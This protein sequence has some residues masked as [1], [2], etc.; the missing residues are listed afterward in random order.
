[1]SEVL[2]EEVFREASESIEVHSPSLAAVRQRAGEQRRRRRSVVAGSAAACAV[3]VGLAT[4]WATR[5]VAPVDPVLTVAPT[6][7]AENPVDVAWFANGELHLDHV[8]IELPPLQELVAISGGAVYA[9]EGGDVVFVA[10]DGAR[11]RLGSKDPGTPLVGSDER[12]WVAWTDTDGREP[13]LVLYDLTSRHEVRTVSPTGSQEEPLTAV[14]IDQDILYY[15]SGE[16]SYAATPNGTSQQLAPGLL[17]VS[18]AT[19]AFQSDLE[20][21]RLE[22]SFFSTV[23]AALGVGAQLSPDGNYV[24]THTAADNS[25]YGTVR[26]YDTRS[27]DE[28]VPI[29]GVGDVAIDAALGS[30]QTV[31]Y[32]IARAEDRPSADGFIRQSFSGA[33]ELRTCVIG[34]DCNTVAKF[35]STG[36]TPVLAK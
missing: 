35:P 8:V 21:I 22:Q 17:D 7:Q 28:V 31:S 13:V 12:G 26:V 33:L 34:G 24:L 27:G 1:M 4:W 2:A 18:S 6:V 16:Q 15:R 32:L 30:D 11:T 9:A 5:P 10:D 25:S 14:A 23:N 20:S 3:V 29:L 19:K 36:S